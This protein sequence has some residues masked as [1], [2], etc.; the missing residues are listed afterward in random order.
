MEKFF[1]FSDNLSF[2]HT[3]LLSP[4]KKPPSIGFLARLIE[5]R[6][7]ASTRGFDLGSGLSVAVMVVND[8][9]LRSAQ[10]LR[11]D[12]HFLLRRIGLAG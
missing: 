6:A 3:A 9:A 10:L 8:D 12:R 4:M 11:M 1:V 7:A 2:T 5:K